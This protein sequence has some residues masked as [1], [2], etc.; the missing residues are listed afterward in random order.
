MD[1]TGRPMNGFVWVRA[2][3]AEGKA[4]RDWLA[5][6]TRYVGALPAKP[7]S[8]SPVHAGASNVSPRKAARARR[9]T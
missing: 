2:A 3:N 1:I 7:V 9:D 8:R 6:S 4:L 5:L